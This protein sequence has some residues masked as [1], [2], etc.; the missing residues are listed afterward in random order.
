MGFEI[1]L[2]SAEV[3]KSRGTTY[4][5]TVSLS[6]TFSDVICIVLMRGGRDRRR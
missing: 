1:A 3:R 6:F 5:W 2:A 4:G